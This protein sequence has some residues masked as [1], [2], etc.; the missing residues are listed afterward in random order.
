V[1]DPERDAEKGVYNNDIKTGALETK[2]APRNIIG[3]LENIN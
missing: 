3:F 2:V 1:S